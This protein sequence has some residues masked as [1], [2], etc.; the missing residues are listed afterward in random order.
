[1][2]NV[3]TAVFAALLLTGQSAAT[4]LLALNPQTAAV[5]ADEADG[6]SPQTVSGCAESPDPVHEILDRLEA[7]AAD[8]DAFTAT[9]F[10]E[11]FDELLD[12]REIRTGEMIYRISPQDDSAGTV[13]SFAVLFESLIIGQRRSDRQKHYVFHDRW[14]A[15]IDH[16]NRQFI[17]REL[18]PPG[19]QLDP[20][21]LGEG[22]I[23][24]PIGQPKD[25]VL[26]RFDV[27]L[28]EA[29][30]DGPLS[31]LDNVDGLLLIPKAN[32]PQA[33]QYRRIELFYDRDT[34]LPVGINAI[35]L[36]D[37]RQTVRLRNVKRN[38]E[39]TEEQLQNLSVEEPDPRQW[40][41]DVRPYR[42][43]S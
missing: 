22:P 13:T 33:E 16:E 7:S 9:I 5:A 4:A 36:N 41:I 11:T 30:E 18:V 17:K 14:L 40:S 32:A 19:R 2:L 28:H 12:R 15:E 24:L 39:L 27:S 20:L 37:D 6:A 42:T 10:Y 38:P 23:P 1:M 31:R 21:K 43:G 35:E 34:N 26:A 8:L 3:L 25:D 29:P